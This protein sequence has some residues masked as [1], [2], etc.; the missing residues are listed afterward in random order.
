[1]PFGRAGWGS[2]GPALLGVSGVGLLLAAVFPL[3][4]D[5]NG[6]IVVF[7]CR[8]VLGLRMLRVARGRP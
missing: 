8:M 5:A 1:M 3:R 4:E 2:A 7:P 6:V